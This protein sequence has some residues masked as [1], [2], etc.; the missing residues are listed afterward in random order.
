[1]QKGPLE[2]SRA[3]WSFASGLHVLI[4]CLLFDFIYRVFPFFGF[5][6]ICSRFSILHLPL[7]TAS[8][9]GFREVAAVGD[10]AHRRHL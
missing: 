1:M 3:D 7:S 9:S 6:F 2:M 5:F 8:A 4:V 10:Q